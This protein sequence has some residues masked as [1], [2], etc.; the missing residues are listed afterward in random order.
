[1]TEETSMSDIKLSILLALTGKKSVSIKAETKSRTFTDGSRQVKV[2]YQVGRKKV[3]YEGLHYDSDEKDSES[4]IIKQRINELKKD[5]NSSYKI[6]EKYN[7]GSVR[8]TI[9][10]S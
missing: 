6:R 10:K 3:G 2:D 5:L 4:E 9:K 1:M 8:L 7:L